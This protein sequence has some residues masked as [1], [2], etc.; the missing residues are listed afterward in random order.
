MDWDMTF[1]P[2]PPSTGSGTEGGLEPEGGSEPGGG[3][4]RKT[5]VTELA[6]AHPSP[7]VPYVP[8]TPYT[9]YPPYA[10]NE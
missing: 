2:S 7:Y 6:E 8:Y 5:P 3:S 9:P 10:P 4:E 1:E